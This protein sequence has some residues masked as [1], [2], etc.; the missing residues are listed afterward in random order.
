MKKDTTPKSPRSGKPAKD[1][2]L[3][4]KQKAFVQELIDNPKQSATQAVLKTYGKPNKPPTYLSARNIASEN[5]TKPNIITKL[6]QYNDIVE[7]TLL[8]TVQDWGQHDKPRQREIAQNAAMYI[9]DKVHGKATQ[10][11][12]TKSE[13]VSININMTASQEPTG[14]DNVAQ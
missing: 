7:S 9:H 14:V 12:E 1:R 11:V 4:P 3:T 10:K 2:P 13:Q 5:L 8:Q 6:A